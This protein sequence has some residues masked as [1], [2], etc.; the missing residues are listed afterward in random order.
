MLKFL[1]RRKAQ[2]NVT[3][4]QRRRAGHLACTSRH[5]EGIK[6]LAKVGV[7][8]DVKGKFGRMPVHFA[9]SSSSNECIEYLLGMQKQKHMDINV[10]ISM[11]RT[12]TAGLRFY[13]QRDLGR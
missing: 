3:D 12:T 7:E 11:W 1:F 9:A 5:A 2:L 10:A 8:L 13:G 6:S 4:S